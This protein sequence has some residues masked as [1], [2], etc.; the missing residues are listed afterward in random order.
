MNVYELAQH[1]KKQEHEELLLR[2][3]LLKLERDKS[4]IQ[5]KSEV[6]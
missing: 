4:L 3:R 2:N 5:K 6:V 1:M